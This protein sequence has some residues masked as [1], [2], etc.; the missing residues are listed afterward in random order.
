ML[1]EHNC[2]INHPLTALSFSFPLL[3]SIYLHIPQNIMRKILRLQAQYIHHLSYF[4]RVII[5]LKYCANAIPQLCLYNHGSKWVAWWEL[6]EK[7]SK[8]YIT[9][10]DDVIEWKHFP[11]YRPFVRGIHRS[12]VNSPHKGQWRGALIF[13]LIYTWINGWVNNG[14]AGDLRHHRAHY[15]VIVIIPLVL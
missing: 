12:P 6:Y 1:D 5:W 2:A 10:H 15:D 9:Q 3:L 8:H 14:E 11:R 7:H 4:Q 13:S